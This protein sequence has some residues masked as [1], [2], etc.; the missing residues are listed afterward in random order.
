MVEDR[1]AEERMAKDL[2]NTL[3]GSGIAA[4]GFDEGLVRL[5]GMVLEHARYEERYEF[6]RLRHEVPA[7]R[8]RGLATALKAAEAV[9]P[10]RPHPGESA[11][12]NVA[13]GLPLA[14]LD[15]M[16]DVLRDAGDPAR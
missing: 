6:P 10:T 4:A 12:A 1:L 7:E 14:V 5:R 13:L 15:R 3:I 16:R 8:L 11:K 2:L 9:A